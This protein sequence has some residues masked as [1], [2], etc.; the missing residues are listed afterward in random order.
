MSEC[1]FSE[2]AHRFIE[3]RGRATEEEENNRGRNKKQLSLRNRVSV[4][5]GLV[6]CV[7]FA[8]IHH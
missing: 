7:V 6:F 5:N 2:S 1:R 8:G 4:L 3:G